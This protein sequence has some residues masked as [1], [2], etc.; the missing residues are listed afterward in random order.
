MFDALTGLLLEQH[1]FKCGYMGGAS[2]SYTRIGS[3][4]IGLMSFG[5][6]ADIIARTRERIEIPFLVDADTGYGNAFNVQRTFKVFEQMGASGIQLEDQTTPKR[7][8]HLT[9][10][11]LISTGEMCGK[12]RAALDVR[13]NPDTL[14]IARTDAIAVEGFDAA[15]ERASAY[16][17]AG[18]DCI[19]VEAPRTDE[20]LEVIGRELGDR[21]PLI[22]NMV[23]GGMTPI[24]PADDLADMGFKIVL[25]PGSMARAFIYAAKKVLETLAEHGTTLPLQIQMLDF[26]GVNEI[27][28][29][30]E[31]LAAGAR[32]DGGD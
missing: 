23:E 18:A 4:D 29:T 13:A 9:G 1:G 11:T 26:E 16:I 28:G 24:H 5:E 10:K 7:C 20:H 25:Y 21:V 15:L 6:I 3:P 19:F 14:L 27:L 8:G 22:A 32:Y 17:D 30:D 12:I 2:L 31:I